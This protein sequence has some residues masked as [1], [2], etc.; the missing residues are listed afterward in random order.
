MVLSNEFKQNLQDHIV[1][2]SFNGKIK[3]CGFNALFLNLFVDNA[4][5]LN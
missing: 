4:Y 3:L 2:I 1:E 5:T